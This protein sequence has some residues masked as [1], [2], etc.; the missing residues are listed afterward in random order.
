MHDETLS[1]IIKDQIF[2]VLK[3]SHS[4]LRSLLVKRCSVQ[5][6]IGLHVDSI[7][8]TEKIARENIDWCAAL[9]QDVAGGNVIPVNF[10]AVAYIHDLF[11]ELIDEAQKAE[12]GKW[13]WD[14]FWLRSYETEY[15]PME[16]QADRS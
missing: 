15:L 1:R 5:P 12:N 16:D 2:F 7:T 3:T 14:G 10:F 13:R 11:L 4:V 9:F 8:N 6:W